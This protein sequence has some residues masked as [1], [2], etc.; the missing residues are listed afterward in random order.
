MTTCS[1]EGCRQ[2]ARARGLCTHHYMK[3]RRSDPEDVAAEREANKLR[4]RHYRTTSP[5]QAARLNSKAQQAGVSGKITVE[6]VNHL[7]AVTHCPVCGGLLDAG[8]AKVCFGYIVTFRNGGLNEDANLQRLHRICQQKR[9][10]GGEHPTKTTPL[11]PTQPE[12]SMETPGDVYA[13]MESISH[14]Q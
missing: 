11:S 12:V 3:S 2:K 7:L 5:G 14:V 6:H 8:D 1:I 13:Y 9:S 4:N 10:V